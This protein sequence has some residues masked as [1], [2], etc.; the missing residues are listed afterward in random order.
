[1]VKQQL[2]TAECLIQVVHNTD[3]KDTQ[4]TLPECNRS[5]YI[6]RGSGHDAGKGSKLTAY[7]LSTHFQKLLQL[8][9]HISLNSSCSSVYCKLVDTTVSFCSLEP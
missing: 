1:M 8:A 9:A 4:L 6:G 2:S 7:I 3:V 5:S